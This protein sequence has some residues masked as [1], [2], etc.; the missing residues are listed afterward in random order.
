MQERSRSQRLASHRARFWVGPP[1]KHAL[2]RDAIVVRIATALAEFR[3][4][5][6]AE[7][8]DDEA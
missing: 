2:R 4:I 3:F 8:E 5:R 1:L 7:P 6:G